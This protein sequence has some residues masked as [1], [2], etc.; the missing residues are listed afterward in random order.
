MSLILL[1]MKVQVNERK[2]ASAKM[3]Q[4]EIGIGLRIKRGRPP[5]IC[6]RQRRVASEISPRDEDGRLGERF[7][8]AHLSTS[9]TTKVLK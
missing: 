2:F 9:L 3:S 8:P 6:V 4:R 7:D 5:L 1:L